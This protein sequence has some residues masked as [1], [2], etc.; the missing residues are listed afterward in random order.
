MVLYLG[1][2]AQ[3][4]GNVN[5]H[6]Y[7]THGGDSKVPITD[8]G[9]KQ[10]YHQ[11]LYLRGY[12]P[13]TRMTEWPLFVSSSM[14]RPKQTLSGS[15][16][17]MGNLF[18]GTPKLHIDPT[19]AEQSFG[20]LAYVKKMQD[21]AA[22]LR[23]DGKVLTGQKEFELAVAGVLTQ[24]SKQVHRDNPLSAASLFGESPN[25]ILSRVKNFINGTL[26][27][28]MQEHKD[29]F[30]ASHGATT[31]AII[32]N[33]FHLPA[34]AWQEIKTPGNCD[35]FVIDGE[36]KKWTIRKI[37]DGEKMAPCDINPIAKFKHLTSDDLPPMPDNVKKEL[38]LG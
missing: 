4:D 28:D 15:L 32:M 30:I 36:S 14:L 31:K 24:F 20:F 10:A 27:R 35:L 18:S 29:I 8:V 1:R 33:W 23:K 12:W 7:V 34:E 19:L 5:P 9:W 21:D 22:A 37:Y 25:F 11:G 13:S 26:Q 17:G 16:L 2:H 3:S 6:A 38:G